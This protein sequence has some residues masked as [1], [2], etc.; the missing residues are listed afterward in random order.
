MGDNYDEAIYDNDG[1]KIRLYGDIMDQD[2]Y[3]ALQ[4]LMMVLA[5][6]WVYR[7]LLQILIYH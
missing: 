2:N 1:S 3:D 7:L 5:L 4:Q 6:V